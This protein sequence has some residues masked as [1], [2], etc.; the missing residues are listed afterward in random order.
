MTNDK[1]QITNFVK[2]LKEYN[3]KFNLTS[4]I[5]DKEIEIKHIEDSLAGEKFIKE[6]AAC[7]DIGSGG[8]FP[9]LP[10][11]IKRED[12]S[13]TLLE[14]T[15][16]KCGFLNICVKELN[17]EKTNVTEGRAEELAHNALHREKY[18]VCTARAV[19]RLN[20]LCEY[21]M[22]FVKPGGL[23]IAYKGKLES[24]FWRDAS[25]KDFFDIP[26][27]A[28]AASCQKNPLPRLTRKLSF[29]EVYENSEEEK[30]EIK[31]AESAVKILGGK[32]KE[33]FHYS[34]SESMG[35]R[36]LVI[37][38]KTSKTAEKYPRGRGLERKKP[39]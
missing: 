20:T 12:I 7:I 19:A 8:G 2:L 4:I 13:Y 29:Q 31:E 35:E 38:E 33:I 3:Q 26:T 18:D 21:C 25:L 28:K 36:T 32:I 37:I 17:L 27:A 22:P 15:G 11:K 6:N 39:L 34:L 23:F 1:L 16:K 5:N 14:S 30:D 24:K 9:A 10:L